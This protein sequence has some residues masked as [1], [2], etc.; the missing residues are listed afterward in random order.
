M[1]AILMAG[2]WV[3]LADVTPARVFSDGVV[4]QAEMPVPVYGTG[5]P[6]EAVTVECRGEKART[7]AG[8][9][10]RWV[11][12]LGSGKPGGPFELTITGKNVT[13]V[14][15]VLYGEVWHA[16]G[17]SNMGFP[18]AKALNGEDEVRRSAHPEIR[19]FR[20]GS[21]V[22]SGPETAGRVSAMAYFFAVRLHEDRKT[23]VGILDTSVSGA[24]IQTFLSEEVFQDQAEL[25][26]RAKRQCDQT[27]H[28]NYRLRVEP[29]VPFAHRG[30]L[31]CQGEG[32]RGNPETYR[33]LLPL[34]IADWRKQWDQ[35]ET[36]FLIVQLVNSQDRR[37][38]PWEGRDCAIREIQSE[39]ARTVPRTGLVVT[40]DLGTKD[41]HYPDKKPAGERLEQA[42]RAIA[43]GDAVE[44]SGPV[45]DR[46]SFEK[47]RAV[48]AFKHLGGG[49]AVRGDHLNGFL[50]AGE[51]RKFV[52][53]EAS[54][55]GGTVVVSSQAVPQ[56]VAVRYGWERNPDCT[57]KS[58][59]GL[60]A[61]PFRSDR[62]DSPYFHDETK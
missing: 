11:A 32:N 29:L 51:D 16:S 9:D 46:A 58:R 55:D 7:Q 18:L 5:E 25:R 56:P 13:V 17:Q 23:P 43:Y 42:A 62:W 50:L 44:P 37:E 27:V 61:S 20:E 40:I 36:P 35:G 34:L 19:F 10:G 53:A 24:V 21:W 39:V 28:E 2:A 47:G 49:L 57:L 60:P 1:I 48:V 8:A 3:L 6:G 41:V 26:E 12:K 22:V 45:F 54:I 4:L 30:V 14:R 59:E 52:R 33:V 15:N 38:V 31:W